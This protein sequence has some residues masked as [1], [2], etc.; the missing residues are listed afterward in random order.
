[1]NYVL[2]ATTSGRSRQQATGRQAVGRAGIGDCLNWCCCYCRVNL[3]YAPLVAAPVRADAVPRRRL[4]FP[5][6]VQMRQ[7]Y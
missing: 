4:V 1:M 3:F 7:Y 5:L 2:A 6:G